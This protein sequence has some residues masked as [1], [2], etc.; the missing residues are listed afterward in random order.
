MDVSG[1]L[2]DAIQRLNTSGLQLGGGT[3]GSPAFTEHSE[4]AAWVTF[5]A[6]DCQHEPGFI[7][8]RVEENLV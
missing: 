6:H 1:S 3:S 4:E 7:I 2:I 5:T 8:L